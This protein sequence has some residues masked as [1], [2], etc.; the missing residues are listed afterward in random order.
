MGRN[1]D[2]QEA[3]LAF[4]SVITPGDDLLVHASLKTLGYFPDGISA[5][6]E[7]IQEALTPA[8]TLIMMTDTRS[9]ARTG[10]FSPDQASET[11]RITEVFRRMPLVVRSVVPMVSFCAWGAR[12]SQYTK[13]YDSHLDEDAPMNRLLANSA[14]IMLLGIGYEKCT[15]YHLAEERHRVPYNTYKT[16][17]GVLRV[18]GQP[19]RSISQTYFVRS[20][21][22]TKKDP[23]RA[24][25]ELE[26]KG[27]VKFARLGDGL[28][29]VFEARE[30][31]RVCMD[32][33][34]ADPRAFLVRDQEVHQ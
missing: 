8:G 2:L 27:L 6:V 15:L 26:A 18:D 34:Q 5:V 25:Q 20:D 22:S 4:R 7:A 19:D 11:G 31:D 23:S 21:L 32:L 9:F 33:L 28:V 30:F 14:K 29:R 13:P 12:A 17:S 1:V 3:K 24:G 16:F 10:V